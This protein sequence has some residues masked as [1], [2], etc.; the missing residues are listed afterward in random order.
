MNCDVQIIKK[1]PGGGVGGVG[2]V[3]G[4]AAGGKKGG[5]Y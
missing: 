3:G 2:G 4:G 1:E 5:A